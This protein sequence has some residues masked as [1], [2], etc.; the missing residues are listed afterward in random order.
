MRHDDEGPIH[1]GYRVGHLRDDA[2]AYRA[3]VYDKAAYVLHMLRG[4]TGDAAFFA[5]LRAYQ[6]GHRYGKAGTDDLR[7]A[8]EKTSGKD[9]RAYFDGWVYE[10]GIGNLTYRSRFREA[11]GRHLVEIRLGGAGLPGPVPVSVVVAHATGAV[12]RTVEVGPLGASLTVEVPSRPKRVEVNGDRGVL[13]R[14]S[15]R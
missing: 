13:A 3:V 5:G 8:L 2:Q 12:S 10:T 9:L 4:V 6:D 1:L 15:G 7:E 11:A 14:V